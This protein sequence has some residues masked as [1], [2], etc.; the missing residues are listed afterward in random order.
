MSWT[1]VPEGPHPEPRRSRAR[2]TGTGESGSGPASPIR[3]SRPCRGRAGSGP[4]SRT[5]AEASRT[6]PPNAPM[7]RPPPRRDYGRSSSTRRREGEGGW[8][9]AR[10]GGPAMC[11]AL[12][13]SSGA[14]LSTTEQARERRARGYRLDSACRGAETRTRSGTV[15]AG[16]R[17]A[18]QIFLRRRARR[19]ER[20]FHGDVRLY[21]QARDTPQV[22]KTRRRAPRDRIREPRDPDTRHPADAP[23]APATF[24]TM[25]S[26]I[27]P[28]GRRVVS[29]SPT[30]P[31]DLE[32]ERLGRTR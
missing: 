8:G 17:I 4:K 26:P 23:G 25:L 15:S 7:G 28:G 18:P 1:R 31:R 24:R 14:S 32:L 27:I 11:G 13:E 29:N 30:R 6:K 9:P 2:D 20:V 19:P 10:G 5:D 21:A 22:S 16:S 3:A 12:R